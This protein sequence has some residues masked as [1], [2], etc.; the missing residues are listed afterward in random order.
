MALATHTVSINPAF[1]SEIK[2]DHHELRQLLHHVGAMLNR[3]AWM[4]METARL[5]ELFAKLRDQLAMH[6]SLEEA[7][8]YFEDA[9]SGA[10][11][12]SR[13]AESLRAQ[14]AELF[15]E[16]C[17]L[18][19]RSEQLPYEKSPARLMSSLSEGFFHFADNLQEHEARESDLILEAMNQDI[20]T[21]D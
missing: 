17:R 4:S 10:P 16:L 14:H 3:P 6:F 8:G 18:A 19:E 5:V 9:I 13:R 21:G 15:S 12:L 2:E 11:H 20:G 7:Y 1:L